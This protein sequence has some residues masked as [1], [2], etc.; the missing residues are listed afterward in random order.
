KCQRWQKSNILIFAELYLKTIYNNDLL[1]KVLVLLISRATPQDPF[2]L[3]VVA[4]LLTKTIPKFRHIKCES[5]E[6][7]CSTGFCDIMKSLH[8]ISS[9]KSYP[10]H[11]RFPL[12]N[13]LQLY[14]E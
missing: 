7:E 13:V 9:D 3:V 10:G 5:N 8:Q 6:K 14:Y 12:M 1:K 2:P 11:T 4:E